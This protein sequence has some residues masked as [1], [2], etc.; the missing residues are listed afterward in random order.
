MAT[1]LRATEIPA[2]RDHRVAAAYLTQVNA[3]RLNPSLQTDRTR[4]IHPGGMKS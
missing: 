3:P 4:C 2:V 1:H